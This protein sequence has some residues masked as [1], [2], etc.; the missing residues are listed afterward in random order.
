MASNDDPVPLPPTPAEALPHLYVINSEEAFLDLIQDALR[1]IRLRVTLEQLRPNVEVT[2]GNLRSAQPDLV[3]LDYV[4]FREEAAHLLLALAS[5]A[6]LKELPVMLASTSPDL[7]SQLADR[8][9]Q[10]VR[11]VLP[12]P[13]AVADLYARLGRLVGVQAP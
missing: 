8:Y 9:P 12:K 1:D 6:D 11:E 5:T 3:L 7:A 10:L 2:L 4:P 13:F